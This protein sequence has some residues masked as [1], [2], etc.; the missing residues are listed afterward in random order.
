MKLVFMGTPDFSVTVLEA[1][2]AEGHEI[3]C[4]YAQPPRPAGRGMS[5]RPTPVHAFAEA[6][7]I[8][9]RTPLSLKTPEEQIRF[10]SLGADAAVVVAYGLLLPK[11]VL[12]APRFG[13]FNVHASLLPR[14]RGAAP[15]QRAI[16]TGDSET[17]VTI[18]RMDEGLDTGAMLLKARANITDETTAAS[19]HDTLAKLGATAIV[20]VL[21]HPS[22]AGE[23]Q[24]DEGVT[25]AQKISKTEAK[26]DFTRNAAEVLRHVH[27]LSPFPGA[28]MMVRGTRVKILKCRM[29]KGSGTPGTFL[30]DAL[31]IACGKGAIQ[32]LELQREGKGAM[33]AE[34]FLRGFAIAAGT[35]VD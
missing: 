2:L 16:M 10:A 17:G 6:R 19:L 14:W 11:P 35:D 15:I 24:P 33:P 34:V 9:V 18:M 8:E 12:D 31:T 25:Y 1:L 30:D 13:C 3:A 5:L 27:G 26:T 22:A 29:A 32:C 28:W 21:K 20:E 4:A 23:P 7:G